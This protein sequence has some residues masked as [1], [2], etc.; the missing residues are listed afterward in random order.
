[1]TDKLSL[2]H[3][4]C[5]ASSLQRLSPIAFAVTPAILYQRALAEKRFALILCG[6]LTISCGKPAKNRAFYS[7][8]DEKQ[9]R[10]RF[11][12]RAPSPFWNRRAADERRHGPGN[13]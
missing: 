1:V 12:P 8:L 6:F 9:A 5:H 3:A 10:K 2:G 7:P 13:A 11:L 4:S